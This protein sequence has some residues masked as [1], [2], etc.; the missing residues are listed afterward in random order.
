MRYYLLEYGHPCRTDFEHWRMNKRSDI[1]DSVYVASNYFAMGGYRVWISFQGYDREDDHHGE[2]PKGLFIVN[3]QRADRSVD[4][5]HTRV[6]TLEEAYHVQ[7]ELIRRVRE[8]D[9]WEAE[10]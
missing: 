2:P 8:Y 7:A 3:I 1:V 4:G 6:D 10:E 5:M 9:F